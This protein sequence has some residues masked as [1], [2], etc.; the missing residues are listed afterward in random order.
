MSLNS[1]YSTAIA[2]TLVANAE[3]GRNP[4]L[5]KATPGRDYLLPYFYVP[6][7]FYAVVTS[8]GETQNYQVDGKSSPIWPPGVYYKSSP[9]LGVG[10][11]VTKQSIFYDAPCSGVITKDNVPI[12]IDLAIVFR[13]MGDESKGENPQLAMDVAIKLDPRDLAIR[14]KAR[15]DQAIKTMAR[16]VE[17]LEVY[18][19]RSVKPT[20]TAGAEA[21]EETKATETEA[22]TGE[23]HS[24][25]APMLQG[26]EVEMTDMARSEMEQAA[27]A[28]KKGAGV[29]QQ[30][31]R[32]LNEAF[33]HDGIE[34]EE[35]IIKDVKLSTV[36][37]GQLANKTMVVSKQ[38][39]DDMIQQRDIM[40]LQAKNEIDTLKQRIDEDIGRAKQTGE[41][42]L[43][44]Y[45]NELN[46][47]KAHTEK[48]LQVIREEGEREARQVQAD[49]DL[50]KSEADQKQNMILTDF[51]SRATAEAQRIS[52]EA[53]VTIKTTMARAE[54]YS[55]EKQSEAD[56]LRAG[57]EGDTA[58]MVAAKK[59]HE[60][61]I[62]KLEVLRSLAGNSD[63]TIAPG[64][65][66]SDSLT[67]LMIADDILATNKLQPA[68]TD[69]RG[70][71]LTDII[72]TAPSSKN[73]LRVTN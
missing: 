60:T 62:K 11:L 29:T 19:L 12:E 5:M 3:F 69:I 57:A 55:A 35:V 30:V 56:I 15:L 26:E 18:G 42:E 48:R 41:R 58:S 7:G 54:L 6:E 51:R 23:E 61:E 34:I 65:G 16:E 36:I 14:L 44:E 64:A 72:A 10:Y 49:A 22:E 38:E 52:T 45:T 17:H 31:L 46:R 9:F 53:S 66:A 28:Q 32:E 39:M 21:A 47:V 59:A 37:Q 20:Q 13:V 68:S 24:P 27:I 4:T 33:R 67:S 25:M 2:N 70:Q 1:L 8:M 50:H 71:L 43:A 73:S 63:V 40:L